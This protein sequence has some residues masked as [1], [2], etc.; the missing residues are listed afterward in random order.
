MTRL[1]RRRAL[2]IGAAACA[3]PLAGAA[4][5]AAEA[6]WTGIALGA[7]AEIRLRH[8]SDAE[9]RPVFAAVEAELARLEAIF[10]LYRADS[11][12]MRLNRDGVLADPPPELIEVL[13]LAGAVHAGTGGLF[14][15][16]VQPL[17]RLYAEAGAAG[18]TVGR[19]ELA[20]ALALVGFDHV[21]WDAG[22]VRTMRP[23]AA[24]TLNGIA[25]GY[26]TDR[27]AALLRG[28]G[29][30]DL[31]VEMGEIAALGS[32]PGGRGWHVAIAGGDRALRLSDRAIATSA[33]L[34]TVLDAGGTVGHILHPRRGWTEPLHRQVSVIDASAARADAFSTA[35]AL[36]PRGALAGLE[37]DRIIV[38]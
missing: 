28:Q 33:P 37:C 34:G 21:H 6:R 4:A 16:T 3:A 35:A 8:L 2:F 13:S 18:R 27:V 17:F 11:T 29:F 36:M 25:Q 24:L 38:A 31:L 1:S 19:D 14:D 20:E 32:G 15:P 9:A 12:L 5:R 23:G 22:S 7:P 26:I 30:A 10:S